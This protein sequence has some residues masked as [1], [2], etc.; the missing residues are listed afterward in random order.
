MSNVDYFD[1]EKNVAAA[2]KAY[3]AAGAR[4]AY[5]RFLAQQRGSRK[6][7][8]IQRAYERQAPRVVSAF[9]QRGLAG[10]GVR[11]GVYQQGMT[12]FAQK[13]FDD[14]ASFQEQY[15]LEMEGFDT[16]D[17]ELLEQYNRRLLDLD[18]IKNMDIAQ[19]AATLQS[20][21][22]FLGG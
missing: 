8:D 17:A 1:Y 16:T 9:T 14:V 12:D 7:F 10:P 13:N 2:D 4:N 21:K 18:N 5:A 19:A 6:K 15:D 11:S 22:P 3:G 20:F